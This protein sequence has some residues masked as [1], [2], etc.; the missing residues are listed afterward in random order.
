MKWPS[1]AIFRRP[2]LR[3]RA[4]G[5]A[6]ANKLKAIM[7]FASQKQIGAVVEIVERAGPLEYL[8]PIEFALYNPA[9]YETGDIIDTWIYRYGL[10][11]ARYSL[12]T[13]VG[14]VKSI[15]GTTL[16]FA[17]NYAAKRLAN[18]QVF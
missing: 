13:A 8:R 3:I 4:P 5:D 16:V 17:S 10:Q 9:V 11:Q 15:V 12:A 18:Y 6:F 14:L 1:T 2:K 7:K